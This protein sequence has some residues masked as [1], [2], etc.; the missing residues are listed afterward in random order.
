MKESAKSQSARLGLVTQS[1]IQ[2]R[3]TRLQPSLHGVGPK[4]LFLSLPHPSCSLLGAFD[5]QSITDNLSSHL[6][7][8]T[9]D[10]FR[11]YRACSACVGDWKNQL[12][13]SYTSR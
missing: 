8:E 2:Q 9:R 12:N 11:R 5:R 7:I 6:S 1:A 13:F 3:V 4:L 10:E